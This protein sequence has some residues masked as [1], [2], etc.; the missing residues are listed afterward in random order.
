MVGW[1]IRRFAHMPEIAEV[2]VATEEECIDRMRAL[3]ARL[4]PERAA[5][6]VRGGASR[7]GSVYEGLA[8]ISAGIDAALVHD[9]ARPLVGASDVR[10]GMREVRPGRAALLA[11]PVVDTIKVVEAQSRSVKAT[12]DRATLWA[13]QTPQFALLADLRAA[14]EQARRDGLAVTDDATLLERSG[15]DVVVV[16]ATGENFKVT[17][18]ADVARA[19]TILRERTPVI[20]VP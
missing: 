1:S 7:Q 16:P 14:H 12:L 2:I 6:V 5:R 9:G 13:A 15:L 3:L 19:E 18:P 8:A 17:L 11:A 10:A 20:G 4:A